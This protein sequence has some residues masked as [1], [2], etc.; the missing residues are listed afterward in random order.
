M[1]ISFYLQA[2]VTHRSSTIK[3]QT[4]QITNKYE[5]RYLLFVPTYAY[6][7]SNYITNAPT[8]F[9][10]PSLESFDIVFC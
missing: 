6:A 9:G 3:T 5:A 1:V 4:R 2:P 8:C 10:A 7:T